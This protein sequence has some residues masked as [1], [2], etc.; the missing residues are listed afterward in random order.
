MNFIKAYDI[1]VDKSDIPK[2]IYNNWQE[3]VDSLAS[4]SDVPAA[5]IMHALSDKIEVASSSKTKPIDNPYNAGDS[6]NLSC[7]LYCETVMKEK[8]EL[9]VKNA[10]KDEDWK[11]NPD[12]SIGMIS[13]YGQ[14]LLWPDNTV[15]GTI[16][17]LDKKDLIPS[18]TVKELLGLFR[19]SIEHD[20]EIIELSHLKETQTEQIKE[21]YIKLE[22][23]NKNLEERV[24]EE[25][26]KNRKK[27]LQ[28]IHQYRLAQMGEMIGNIAHQ[29]RQPLSVISTGSTGMKLQKEF[30]TLCDEDFFKTCDAINNNAQY[31]SRTIDDFKNFIKGNR[32]RSKFNLSDVLNSFL[33]LVDSS[34]DQNSI[35]QMC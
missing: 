10:L 11:N 23:L 32:K 6:D 27:E 4:I 34:K 35:Y 1:G 8:A 5:L 33:H 16:C 31:L 2:K 19:N 3:I 28:I 20:L 18:A 25:V 13:Y 14:P 22:D 15:F 30:G 9:H 7:S 17:I 29:W 24:K 12:V 21:Q 26:E